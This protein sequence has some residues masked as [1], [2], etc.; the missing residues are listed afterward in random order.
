MEIL[1]WTCSKL[2]LANPRNALY[3]LWLVWAYIHQQWAVLALNPHQATFPSVVLRRCFQ[4]HMLNSDTLSVAT[5]MTSLLLQ[6]E[7]S[8]TVRG[9]LLVRWYPAVR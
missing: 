5:K 6:H 8:L 9:L 2:F 7:A 3:A 1:Y 4:H